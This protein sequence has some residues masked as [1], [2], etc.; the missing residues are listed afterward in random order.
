M[1]ERRRS[2]PRATST[3]DSR[4]PGGVYNVK[5][6]IP[7]LAQLHLL[8]PIKETVHSGFVARVASGSHERPTVGRVS[9]ATAGTRSTLGAF[10]P[11]VVTCGQ[12][13]SVSVAISGLVMKRGTRGTTILE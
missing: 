1:T 3:V 13:P 2:H 9:A 12:I 7:K 6:E 10:V 5:L 11:I 8:M 4:L